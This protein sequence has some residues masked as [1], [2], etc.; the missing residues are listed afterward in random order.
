MYLIV[1]YTYATVTIIKKF[2]VNKI[3]FYENYFIQQGCNKLFKSDSKDI[4]YVTNISISNKCCSF[5]LSTHLRIRK[6]ASRFP[7]KY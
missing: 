3:F 6:N 5:E 1:S 7:Q 2:R 4:Y